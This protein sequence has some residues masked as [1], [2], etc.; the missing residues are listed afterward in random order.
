MQTPRLRINLTSPSN[1]QSKQSHPK[2][3]CYTF[4]R[5]VSCIR[6]RDANRACFSVTHIINRLAYRIYRNRAPPSFHHRPSLTEGSRNAATVP[7]MTTV[8][9]RFIDTTPLRRDSS[10]R[11]PHVILT[12]INLEVRS[13]NIYVINSEFLAI[14]KFF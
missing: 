1:G 5:A 8:T 9:M 12:C 2:A 3:G 13:Q 6:C 10:T 11:S 4:R 7:W 14:L